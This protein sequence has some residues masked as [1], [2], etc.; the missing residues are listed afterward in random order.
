MSRIFALLAALAVVGF[1]ATGTPVA[2]LNPLAVTQA[3]AGKA[4]AKEGFWTRQKA[5]WATQKQKYAACRKEAR[6]Q[7]LRGTKRWSFVA[8]CMRRRG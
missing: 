8:R 1:F 4:P 3:I 5:K 2:P 6:D 7:N